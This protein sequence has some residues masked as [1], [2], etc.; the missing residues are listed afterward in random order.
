[1]QNCKITRNPLFSLF[2]I[3]FIDSNLRQSVSKQSSPAG[4]T[5]TITANKSFLTHMAEIMF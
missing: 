5:V 2:C 4:D 3:H 1:M